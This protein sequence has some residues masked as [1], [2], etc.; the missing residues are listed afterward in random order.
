MVSGTYHVP[1]KD[2]PEGEQ[3]RQKLALLGPELLSD[4][5][6]LAILLRTGSRG[7]DVVTFSVELLKD[8]SGVVGLSRMA[9]AELEECFGIGPGK[10]TTLKA[11]FEI[12]RRAL[13]A[14]AGERKQ[15]RSAQ[16]VASL[17]EVKLRGLDQEQLHVVLLTTKNHVLATRKIYDGSLNTS[18]VRPA[19]VFRDAIRENA[20][21]IIVAHNHPSGDPT[22]SPDDVSV[23]RDLAAA[24]RL[25][26]IEL[27]D[28]PV[29]GDQRHG[30][31]SLRERRLGFDP[32]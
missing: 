16:D 2:W 5:E 31:V 12:G 18:I 4:A 15:V 30:Y 25:L 13:M 1:V 10:A 7:R 6:L 8:N 21:S 14:E 29:I 3:P 9:S 23:T 32:E 26:D 24:G 11:A 19:E 27:L 28:H 20:A 22:P 17:M